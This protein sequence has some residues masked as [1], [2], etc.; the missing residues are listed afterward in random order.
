[1]KQK[2]ITTA[3]KHSLKKKLKFIISIDRREKKVNQFLRSF[4]IQGVQ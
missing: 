3:K 4:E 1:M 2:E